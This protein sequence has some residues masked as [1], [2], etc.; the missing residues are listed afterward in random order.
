METLRG[1]AQFCTGTLE[2][3]RQ[4]TTKKKVNYTVK[5]LQGIQ[6]TVIGNSSYLPHYASFLCLLK[7]FWLL[8]TAHNFSNGI[9]VSL[10]PFARRDFSAV[11]NQH[12]N[13]TPNLFDEAG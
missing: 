13:K 12:C 6:Q 9:R 3:C 8:L 1:S 7:S 4:L 2:V 5:K 10:S 11:I